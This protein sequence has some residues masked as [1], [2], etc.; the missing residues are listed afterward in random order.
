MDVVDAC[1]RHPIGANVSVVPTSLLPEPRLASPRRAANGKFF[2]PFGKALE[3][4]FGSGRLD[5]LEDRGD[6]VNLV[7]WAQKNMA[8]VGH[9]HESPKLEIAGRS[10]GIEG[11]DEQFAGL[12]IKEDGLSAKGAEREFV[13]V[14]REVVGDSALS[15]PRACVHFASLSV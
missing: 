15:R 9:D 14:V 12:G 11:F 5:C 13:G 2:S 4:G 10:S 6:G 7:S 3:D 1:C 8:V